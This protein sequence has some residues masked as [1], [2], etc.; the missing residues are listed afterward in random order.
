[1]QSIL[2]P[3][4]TSTA[5]P[6]TVGISGAIAARRMPRTRLTSSVAPES[7]APV[8]PAEI[9]AS[10]SPARSICSPTVMDESFFRR[11]ARAG[12]SHISMVSV[13]WRIVTPSGSVSPHCAA[14]CRIS[15]SRP[16]STMSTP[17]SRWACRAPLTISSGALSP[18]M[19]S[20]MILIR[21]QLLPLPLRA[22]APV[23]RERVGPARR[24]SFSFRPAPDGPTA[25]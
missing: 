13:Q 17:K 6:P 1:M 20:R 4:S 12:S 2:A 18:P 15:S 8:L 3:Q 11:Q 7:S 9:K 25:A 14:A 22:A 5:S 21:T 23:R 16:V 24:F 19:A 10:P